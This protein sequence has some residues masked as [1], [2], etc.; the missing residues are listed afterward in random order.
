[1]FIGTLRL[2]LQIPH[3]HSLKE[4]RRPLKSMLAQLENRFC[5]AVAEVG[6]QDLHQRA[7]VAVAVVG[8]DGKTVAQ[9]LQ[10]IRRFAENQPDMLSP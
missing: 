6:Y 3:A 8:A 7:A 9:R 10:A 5:C 4:K 2:E 1:M